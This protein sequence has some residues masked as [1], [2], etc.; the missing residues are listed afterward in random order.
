M[1]QIKT[2][3]QFWDYDFLYCWSFL[4]LTL[5]HINLKF[6]VHKCFSQVIFRKWTVNII[7][8]FWRN[9]SV[10]KLKFSF[11]T[12]HHK[13]CLHVNFK[14]REWIGKPVEPF[15]KLIITLGVI[16]MQTTLCRGK[17][18]GRIYSSPRFILVLCKDQFLSFAVNL[19][20][21]LV[22]RAT[23]W[24]EDS[25]SY[26]YDGFTQEIV[27]IYFFPNLQSS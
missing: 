15:E 25:R 1:R 12:L 26:T 17:E 14:M 6:C 8:R 24:K 27:G 18:R 23:H 10:F 19:W 3:F 20:T 13:I 5:K 7:Y 11:K 22:Y 9:E 4:F 21:M 2:D 16:N